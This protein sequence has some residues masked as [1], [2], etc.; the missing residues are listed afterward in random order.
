MPE[1]LEIPKHNGK[2]SIST[3]VVTSVVVI[4]ILVLG[5]F[6]YYFLSKSIPLTS[7]GFSST[8]VKNNNKNNI[9]V[10]PALKEPPPPQIIPT[11]VINFTP[12]QILPVVQKSGKCFASSIAS[13]F[14]QD[15]FRCM[16]GS[17]IY[18][19]CFTINKNGFVYCQIGIDDSTGFL[20][21]LTQAL[22]RVS[23]PK[24]IQTNWAWYLKLEDGTACAPFTGSRPNFGSDIAYYGCKSADKEQQIVLV[25]DLI[26]GSVWLAKEL[27][28]VK[29]G[30]SWVTKSSAQVKINT[31]WK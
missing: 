13:P 16:V 20:M 30:T 4:I 1:N 17:S 26:E 9:Q 3:I 6:L 14:R 27:I 25:G 15:A 22:P 31:V 12:P 8:V 24:N 18:D 19:P 11:N 5:F 7:E 23:V 2:Y 29:N 28:V 21:K 10:S